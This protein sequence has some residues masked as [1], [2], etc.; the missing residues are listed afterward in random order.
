MTIA[1]TT[2]SAPTQAMTTIAALVPEP[3]PFPLLPP[4]THAPSAESAKPEAHAHLPFSG[5]WCSGHSE[6]QLW[7]FALRTC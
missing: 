5:V 4:V 6:T 1:A 2:S 7:P 3:P